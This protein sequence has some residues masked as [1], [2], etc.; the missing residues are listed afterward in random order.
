[1]VSPVSASEGRF[2]IRFISLS[3]LLFVELCPLLRLDRVFL[4]WLTESSRPSICFLVFGFSPVPFGVGSSLL[5]WPGF[6]FLVSLHLGL[7]QCWAGF[8]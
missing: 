6:S 1:M 8:S 2:W 4:I 7:F 5:G 3:N